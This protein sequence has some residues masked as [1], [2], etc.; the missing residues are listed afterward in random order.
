M[1]RMGRLHANHK[2]GK[3]GYNIAMQ[4]AANAVCSWLG[5]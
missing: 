4:V 5:I 2:I 1:T 3:A